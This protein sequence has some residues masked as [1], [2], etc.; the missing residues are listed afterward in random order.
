MTSGVKI[1]LTLYNSVT[2]ILS[3]SKYKRVKFAH[4]YRQIDKYK[5]YSTVCSR[6]IF[7]CH[8]YK[9]GY[10]KNPL[11]I[12]ICVS[13]CVCV[14]GICICVWRLT[15]FFLLCIIILVC[16]NLLTIVTN[17]SDNNKKEYVNI[18]RCF[19][20]YVAAYTFSYI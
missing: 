3:Q 14:C 10:K 5:I 1:I 13:V 16:S 2:Y 18:K 9:N 8:R 6:T 17:K 7:N 19:I 4:C 11:Y 20:T 15:F 12:R